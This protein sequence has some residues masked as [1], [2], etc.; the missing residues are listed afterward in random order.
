MNMNMKNKQTKKDD[1]YKSVSAQFTWWHIRDETDEARAESPLPSDKLNNNNDHPP[2][3][4]TVG[5]LS[6]RR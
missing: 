5:V 1:W 4:G 6:H 3:A 2:W